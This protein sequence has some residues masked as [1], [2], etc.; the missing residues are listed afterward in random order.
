VKE[1]F[2]EVKFQDATLRLIETAESI[3]D[4]YAEQ[5]YKLTLRQVYYQLIARDLFPD[6]RWFWWDSRRGKW[7]RDHDHANPISTKNADPNYKWLGRIVGDARLAG[8]IDWDMIEDRARETVTPPHW[9]SPAEIVGAAAR[10]FRIDKWEDQENHVEV[11]VEKD[12][13]SGVLG[14]VCTELDIR[15]TA[16]RGY[17][18]LSHFYEIGKRLED[19]VQHGKTPWIFY[20]GDHDPSG[21][22]MDRDIKDRLEMFSYANLEVVRLGLTMEQVEQFNPPPNP[23]K[24][25]DS[26]ARGYIV[27]FGKTSW[28]LDALDPNTLAEL[29]REAVIPLRDD[30][31]WDAQVERETEMR[32]ELQAFV[33]SY[34]EKHGG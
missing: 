10:A 2:T 12:A 27:K 21:L 19:T 34:Q 29:V 9:D 33:K 20:L 1:Q 18:S 8:L 3:L 24:M 32:T 11:M 30:D 22:D 15:F 13:L 7:V 26:R 25:T 23:A 16:N 14:P 17:S 31:L 28:E 4:E 6:D 5:G